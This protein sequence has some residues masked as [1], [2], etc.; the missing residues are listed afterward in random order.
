MPKMM[1][2][3]TKRRFTAR[4]LAA[5]FGVSYRSILR[6][7][8]ELS[9]LGVPVYSETGANGGY[10]LLNEPMLRRFFSQNL[11]QLPCFLPINLC[12]FLDRSPLKP[13]RE[14]F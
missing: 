2:I 6:D 3:H 14:R 8:D 11:K 7:L 5:E 13:K 10:Y 9:A 1:T 12:S 4:E